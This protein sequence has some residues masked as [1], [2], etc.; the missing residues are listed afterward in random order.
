MWLRWFD[1]SDVGE[2]DLSD[3]VSAAQMLSSTKKK[4]NC[5]KQ[6]AERYLLHLKTDENLKYETCYSFNSLILSN[7]SCFL[8]FKF[9]RSMKPVFLQVFIIP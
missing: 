1:L 5:F 9:N 2:K 7:V 4:Y 6:R 8:L 3:Y